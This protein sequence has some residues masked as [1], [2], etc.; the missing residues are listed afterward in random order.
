M[1]RVFGEEDRRNKQG[2]IISKASARNTI[3]SSD[4]TQLD[5]AIKAALKDGFLTCPTAF[6]IASRLRI[7]L[8]WVGDAVDKLGIRI[9]ECQLGCFKIEKTA[10]NGQDQGLVNLPIVEQ[11]EA[12]LVAGPFTCY[13]AFDI[14][15]RMKI[16]PCKVG[17][18]ANKSRFKI[19]DC[20]L[21]CF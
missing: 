16:R 8:Q 15:R 6:G 13:A 17:E 3:S 21:G 19:R 10:W 18:A 12:I 11:I 2:R 9:V 1:K 14:A 5:E 7:P 20:Q 4:A